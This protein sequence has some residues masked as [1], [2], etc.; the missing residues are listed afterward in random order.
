[1]DHSYFMV[2]DL[3]W[4]RLH[5]CSNIDMPNSFINLNQASSCEWYEVICD[6]TNGYQKTRV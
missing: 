3:V 2:E 5:V 1:M 6:Y 4:G